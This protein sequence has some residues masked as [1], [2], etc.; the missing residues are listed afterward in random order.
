M[1]DPQVTAAIIS[2]LG[3]ITTTLITG[4]F[5]LVRKAPS[6][7]TMERQ[8]M[9]IEMMMGEMKGLRTD[10]RDILRQQLENQKEVM[11]ELIKSRGGTL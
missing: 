7:A 6:G 5:V 8:S 9:H 2:L 10:T 4:I 11:M 1:N 3:L